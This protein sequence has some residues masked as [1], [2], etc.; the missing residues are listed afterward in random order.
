MDGGG[1]LLKRHS[2]R[3]GL[4]SITVR[5]L[6]AEAMIRCSAEN[7]NKSLRVTGE[8]LLEMMRCCSLFVAVDVWMHNCKEYIHCTYNEVMRV[9]VQSTRRLNKVLV[10]WLTQYSQVEGFGRG[11]QDVGCS[12]RYDTCITQC[13]VR[14]EQLVCLDNEAWIVNNIN[15]LP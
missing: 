3:K 10:C 4:P 11:A 9:D 8:V 13:D 15:R 5:F 1:S 7:R 2:S 6:G 14:N 12:A